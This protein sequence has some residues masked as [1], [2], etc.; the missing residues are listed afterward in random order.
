M[1]FDMNETLASKWMSKDDVPT[2]GVDLIIRQIT[3][4]QVGDEMEDKFAMH[5]HGSYKPLLLNRTNIRIVMSLYGPKS[6][7]WIN[8]PICVYNDPTISYGGRL[9]GGVR[10]RM[11]QAARQPAPPPPVNAH[12]QFNQQNTRETDYAVAA[13]RP[14]KSIADLADDIPF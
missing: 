1:N 9:T 10:L 3:Q 11:A 2:Q 14:V 8:Q 12:P 4:E 13:G 6:D 7:A 5:F